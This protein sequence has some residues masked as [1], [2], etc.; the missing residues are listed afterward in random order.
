MLL[1]QPVR[2]AVE[3]RGA[4]S[5]SSSRNAPGASVSTMWRVHTSCSTRER[6][7]HAVR[8]TRRARPRRGRG[9]RDL[10]P[11]HRGLQTGAPQAHGL[12]RVGVLP[13]R[14]PR[15]R[16][17][18]GTGPWRP[19]RAADGATV[20]ATVAPKRPLDQGLRAVGSRRDARRAGAGSTLAANSSRLGPG[21]VGREAAGER[22]ERRA[23][24]SAGTCSQPG[25]GP[26]RACRPRYCGD[27]F[28][29]STVVGVARRGVECWP[30]VWNDAYVCASY[31]TYGADLGPRLV[32]VV[33]DVHEG[34]ARRAPSRTR[35]SKPMLLGLLAVRVAHHGVGVHRQHREPQPRRAP[36]RGG[37][38]PADEHASGA[39][40]SRASGVT[41]T[42]RPS[43][44]ERLARPAPA[45]SPRRTPRGSCRAPRA[46]RPAISN[47]STR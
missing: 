5:T 13:R 22:V 45:A 20:P 19:P 14:Q 29:S 30:G 3:R 39:V 12:D 38:S 11:A 34:R 23:R 25:R 41:R 27:A 16:R 26:G 43:P 1:A 8:P 4:S 33:G 7:A 44:L 10:E 47:S 28:R 35:P 2:R 31:S 9:E 24:P 21:E 46:R 37:H 32:R 17:N 42:V 18:G 36:R 6:V 15:Q 40:R